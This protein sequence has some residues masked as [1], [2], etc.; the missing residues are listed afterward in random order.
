MSGNS[1]ENT[2]CLLEAVPDTETE[3]TG[4]KVSVYTKAGATRHPYLPISSSN[5]AP[6][7]FTCQSNVFH[8]FT[9]ILKPCS[10]TYHQH[11]T[12]SISLLLPSECRF[13][14]CQRSWE[15][16]QKLEYLI[17]LLQSLQWPPISLRVQLKV[18]AMASKSASP[19]LLQSDLPSLT[20]AHHIPGN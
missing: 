17:L 1:A 12:P 5:H 18:F 6:V 16:K 8:Y 15:N 10:L 3:E 19:N 9:P 14:L 4:L 11:L 7:I 13:S 20:P 2:V